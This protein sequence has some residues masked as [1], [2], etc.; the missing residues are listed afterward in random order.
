MAKVRLAILA[1][2]WPVVSLAVTTENGAALMGPNPVRK[3]VTLMQKMQEKVEEEGEKEEKLYEKYMCYCK[4]NIEKLEGS[5]RAAKDKIPTLTNQL[6]ADK[7]DL[8]KLSAELKS[9]KAGKNEAQQALDE[10]TALREKEKAEFDKAQREMAQTTRSVDLAVKA[11]EK[12]VGKSFLQTDAAEYLRRIA[13]DKDGMEDGDRQELMAFLDSSHSSGS[14]YTPA[15]GQIIGMLK[16]MLDESIRDKQEAIE[17]EEKAVKEYEALKE[18]KTKEAKALGGKLEEQ[19]ERYGDLR[20]AVVQNQ[21]D[22]EDTTESLGEDEKYL[23]GLETSCKAKE[24]E[25]QERV[26]TRQEE[27]AALSDTIKMLSNDDALDLMKSSL[28]KKTSFVQVTESASSM[29]ARAATHLQKH[30]ESGSQAHS[31]QLDLIFMALHGKQVGMEKVVQ[32]ID[33]MKVTLKKDQVNDDKKRDYCKEKF[34]SSEDKQKELTNKASDKKTAIESAK[35]GLS[36]L[37]DDIKVLSDGIKDLDQDVAQ[38]TEQRKEEHSEYSETTQGNQAAEELLNMAKKRLNKFYNPDAA[39]LEVSANRVEDASQD[40][41]ADA[42]VERPEKAPEAPG[43]KY[44]KN[45]KSGGVIGMI[46]T[47]LRDIGMQMVEAESEEKHSQKDY[48]EL[49]QDSADKR[50][51]DSKS[52]AAKTEAK[53][54]LDADLQ[55]AEEAQ[56]SLVKELASTEKFILN[57][58]AECDWLLKNYEVRKE[59]RAGEMESL[60]KSKAVLRGADYSLVQEDDQRDKG[61]L[62]RRGASHESLDES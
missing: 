42:D 53:G 32:M 51:A 16:A 1:A 20:V 8:E 26:K 10:A 7:Q 46:D 28:G 38:A 54:D 18:A 23:S 61:F 34:D 37:N 9:G 27:L 24:G 17:A 57:L 2:L 40:S 55:A 52:L 47:L 33:E 6:E 5:V 41:D 14:D 44:H 48:Q 25:Q 39:L 12:G 4:K 50:A 19:M 29:K 3:V 22:L 62:A 15:S 30:K 31:V 45:E 59:A 43:G 21:A 11:L 58:H 13:L 60:D 35:E 36:Q 49:M 56:V